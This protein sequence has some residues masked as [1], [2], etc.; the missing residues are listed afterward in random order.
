MKYATINPVNNQTIKEFD[1]DAFPDLDISVNAFQQWRKVSVDERGAYLAKVAEIL[2]KNKK[3]YAELITLEMGKPLSEAEYEINKVLTGF[4]YYIKSAVHFLKDEPVQTNASKSYIRFEPMGIIFSVMPW[5]FPFWQVFRFAIPTLISGNVSILK[6]SPN[7]PQCAKAIADIFVE[8]GVPIGVF[9]NYFLTNEDAGKLIADKRISGISF[10]GSDATGSI[11]A[12][13]AGKHIKKS[14]LE[15]GGN[16]AFIVLDDADLDFAVSGAVKSRSINSGQ[17]CNAAKRFIVVE[18]NAAPFAEKLLAAVKN[19]NVGD[20]MNATVQIG[21]L[22]RRDLKEKVLKQIRDTVT[23][24]AVAHYGADVPTRDGNFVSPVVLTG[25]KPGMRAFEEEIF[26][27]VWS[28]I[29]VRNAEE[30]IATANNSVY[31][32]G[33]SIWTADKAGAER[34]VSELETGNVFINDIVKSDARIPFGGIKRSGYGREL[35]EH[36]LMEFVNIKTVYIN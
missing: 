26:G 33:A 17:S 20:P 23:A 28:V 19:L 4:D 31:G 1:F 13:Q 10:T 7:V 27:P 14:V 36:G 35:S 18:K 3:K 9:K 24:G 32:L 8:A 34:F 22:A 11:L 12:S 29:I 2:G 6:H 5:N 30:A 15:L 16:D 21:P 25:V